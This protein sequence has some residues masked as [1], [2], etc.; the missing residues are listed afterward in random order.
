MSP[1]AHTL[2]RARGPAASG[3]RFP[4]TK[5]S[6]VLDNEYYR[7]LVS[8]EQNWQQVCIARV[9]ISIHIKITLRLRRIKSGG[10]EQ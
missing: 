8:T 4:W 1:G 5:K 6:F 7:D 3:Y 9:F 2:G 10:F